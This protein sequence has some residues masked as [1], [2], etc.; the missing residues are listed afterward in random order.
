MV[1]ERDAALA[2]ILLKTSTSSDDAS[3]KSKPHQTLG[4]EVDTDID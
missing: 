4:I 1:F 2:M 3:Q